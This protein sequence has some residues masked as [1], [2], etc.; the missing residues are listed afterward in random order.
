MGALLFGSSRRISIKAGGSRRNGRR[1]SLEEMSMACAEK[2][3]QL[4]SS[5]SPTQR[6][7]IG[8]R[9]LLRLLLISLSLRLQ[10]LPNQLLLQHR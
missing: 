7:S 6:D 10:I 9:L 3:A 4:N 1:L 8:K 5:Q 2:H